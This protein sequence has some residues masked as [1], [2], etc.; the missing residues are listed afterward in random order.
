[1]GGQALVDANVLL[2]WRN[3]RDQ[4]HD[5][6]KP[7]VDAIDQ[8]ELPRG[9]VTSFSLMEVITPIQHRA[10]GQRAVEMLDSITKSGGFKIRHVAQEDFTRAQALIRRYPDVDLPDLTTV[11]HMQRTDIEYIYSFDDDLD[12]FDDITRLTTATNPFDPE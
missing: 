1:M 12:R 3:R 9:I 11:A 2:G 4:W 6:A 10:D 8:G 5:Q 7:I